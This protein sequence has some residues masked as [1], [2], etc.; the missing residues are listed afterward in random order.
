MKWLSTYTAPNAGVIMRLDDDFEYFKTMA[1]QRLVYFL[2]TA[3][4][5]MLWTSQWLFYVG[6]GAA[7]RWIAWGFAVVM[8]HAVMVK[9]MG[10][11][12]TLYLG[13]KETAMIVND[14]GG[15]KGKKEEEGKDDGENKGAMEFTVPYETTNPFLDRARIFM[16]GRGEAVCALLLLFVWYFPPLHSL[17]VRVAIMSV[18]LGMRVSVGSG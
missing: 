8:V 4:L 14:G 16:A 9:S 13:R 17:S 15:K 6:P 7:R 12:Q 18:G 1:L 5:M 10:I 2:W 11:W 3:F